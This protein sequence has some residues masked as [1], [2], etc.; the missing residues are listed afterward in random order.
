MDSSC[1]SFQAEDSRE[2]Q[3]SATDLA[4]EHIGLLWNF[5]RELR[6]L[7]DTVSRIQAVLQDAEEKQFR[8]HQVKDWLEKLSDVM[9]DA[10][11]LL[12]DFSTAARRKAVVLAAAATTA[13]DGGGDRRRTPATTCW[14]LVCFL[15]SSLPQQLWYDLTMANAIKAIREKLDD[16]SKDKETLHLEVHSVEEGEALHSSRETDSC[17]PTIVVGREDDK[18]NIIGLLL[19]SNSESNISVV[20]IVG[21]GGLGKTTLAQLVYDDDQANSHFDIKAWVYVSQSFNVKVILGKML[22]SIDRD[23]QVGPELDDLQAQLREKIKGKRFLFVLDDV[24]EETGRSWET[25]GKY[26]TVGA[27]GSKVLVTTRSTK[28]AE[29]GVGALKSETST[30]I[31]KS[32]YLKG[33][34]EEECWN[35]LVKKALPEGVPQDPQVQEIGKQI[36]RK[37]HGVPL[38]VS[39]IAGVLV[40]STDPSTQ[41]PSFLQ[42]GLSSVMRGEEDPIMSALQLSFNHLP[43]HMK[44]CFTY[45]KLF[46]KGFRFDI[47]TLVR[48]WVAQGYIESEDRGFDC[49]KT[50]WWRSFFQEVWVDE[51]GIISTCR[52]HDLMHDLADSVAGEKIVRSSSLTI[53]KNIPSKTRHLTIS[54]DD[55]DEPVDCGDGWGNISKVRTLLCFKSLSNNELEQVLN[56]LLRVRVLIIA[57]RNP[58]FGEGSSVLDAST[59]PISFDKMM[60]LRYL[61]LCC[62]EWKKLPNSIT[63]L[64]N[65]QVLKLID[66]KWLE[67]L[68]RDTKKLVDLK[69]L[70]LDPVCPAYLT[71]MPKGI[72]GLKFLRTLPVFAVGKRSNN[73]N[74]QRQGAG[75]DELKGLNALYGELTI[76][77]LA[78]ADSPRQGCYVLKEKPHLLS[79]NLYL[80]SSD[81]KVDDVTF[82]SNRD[83]GILEMLQPT[84]SN[85][86]K[87]RI[88]DVFQGAKLPI[89]LSG[90]TNLVE[91]VLKDCKRCENLPPLHQMSS[92]RKLAIKNCPLL[93]GIDNDDDNHDEW[94]RFHNLSYLR[95]RNCPSLIRLPT[96]PTVEGKLVLENVSLA[97]FSRTMKMRR[98]REGHSNEYACDT[99]NIHPLIPS[100][101]TS[102]HPLSKLTKLTLKRVE[103][104]L[105]SISGPDLSSCLASLQELKVQRCIQGKKLPSSLCSSV[106]LTEI[107]L[108]W[109]ITIEYLP[110]LHELPSLRGLNV[111]YCFRLKGCWWKKKKK[112]TGN[113]D[114]DN[115][116]DDG[117]DHYYNFDPSIQQDDKEMEEYW[118]RFPRL[119]RLQ[120][121]GCPMLIRMPLF[122]TA[123]DSLTLV[124]TSSQALELTMKM[125]PVA[126]HHHFDS[127]Q[128]STTWATTTTTTSTTTDARSSS[129]SFP[130]TALVAPLSKLTHL[131][132]WHI[133][134]LESLPEEGLCHLSSLIDLEIHDCPKLATLPPAMRRLTSLQ[135]LDIDNCA[136]L[137]E[138]CKQE[139]WPNIS[140]VPCVLLNKEMVHD[141]EGRGK[142][143]CLLWRSMM[144]KGGMGKFDGLLWRSM[145]RKL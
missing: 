10:D 76:K 61:A 34:S 108:S 33:L 88:H 23:A 135:F 15:F 80:G 99:T 116:K 40:D 86:K 13:D 65:L 106:Y 117:D 127:Q 45:C 89:W 9:Y 26:L 25:L 95:I 139:D 105:E 92:L 75:L 49:F 29:V 143:D 17:P 78:N 90:L 137:T 21:M 18:K 134:D 79:L 101:S 39:T 43:S 67:E 121:T 102:V 114:N 57:K 46:P 59:L 41:W 123:E 11:D 37:C 94:P 62:T 113:D 120:I 93:K 64:V 70:E 133:Y 77:G 5:K 111:E 47:Q 96:F 138:R 140:H 31:V 44:H 122:P 136:Q 103:D 55:G 118:P 8:N 141:T 131:K 72:G 52:M 56:N 115:H 42:K 144:R 38:A 98:A 51:L 12:D 68:P 69:H 54:A 91:F 53:L 4:L 20:P 63:N 87:L 107:F 27:L 48:L 1:R 129:S 58:N 74:H 124:G 85:L 81:D 7:K 28:V 36:L 104:D 97:P 71:H 73:G 126:A 119:S 32:Y 100:S 14:S 16:I 60:H 125:K 66:G 145:M 109:C 130:R 3:Y 112:T 6:K 84:H 82:L 35:L 24:W 142:F 2:I 110:P 22:R 19:N 132:L 50:L 83:E 30:S 128:H